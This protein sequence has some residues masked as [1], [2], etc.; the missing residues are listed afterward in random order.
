L[1]VG[2]IL[3]DAALCP[4]FV[5]PYAEALAARGD[6]LLLNTRT[7]AAARLSDTQDLRRAMTAAV[8]WHDISRDGKETTM[9][10]VEPTHCYLLRESSHL[11]LVVSVMSL[12]LTNVFSDGNL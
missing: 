6:G 8:V 10:R 9:R 11:P 5:N 12:C 4:V 3:F 7:L 2:E 1:N